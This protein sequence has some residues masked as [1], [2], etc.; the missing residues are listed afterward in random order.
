MQAKVQRWGN[1]LAVRIPK[2]FAEE[3]GLEAGTIVD[4]R[5]VDEGLLVARAPA[6]SLNLDDLLDGVTKA[7]SHAEVD[8]G[9]SQGR[10]VR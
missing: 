8:A 6:E 1:S 5:L 3:V 9:P 10:E 4:M 2:P 7:N